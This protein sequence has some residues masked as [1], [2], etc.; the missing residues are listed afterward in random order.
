MST[1]STLAGEACIA[2]AKGAQPLTRAEAEALLTHLP[3]W[4]LTADGK[5]LRRR[6]EFRN[7]RNALA[8]V[9]QLGEVAEAAKHHPDISFGWGYAE[10]LYTT[11]SLG[12][13]HRN[14]F[15]L[16]A[17]TDVLLLGA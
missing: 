10:V 1:S 9:N 8:F 6:I 4:E 15:I 12:G 7:F 5:N 3:D 13:L 16:A 17:R 2:H 11:H 14:D